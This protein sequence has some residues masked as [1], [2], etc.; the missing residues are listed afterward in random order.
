MIKT[1]KSNIK[2]LILK[3]VSDKLENFK[4]ELIQIQEKQ[5]KETKSN[6]KKKLNEKLYE[7]FNYE[8]NGL[9]D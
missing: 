4:E 8:M 7:K 1:E 9:K 6:L 3:E 2:E 5:F